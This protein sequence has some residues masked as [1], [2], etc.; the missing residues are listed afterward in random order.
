MNNLQHISKKKSI[1]VRKNEKK[2]KLILTHKVDPDITSFI[3]N[4][5]KINDEDIQ[6]IQQFQKEVHQ[7]Q[8]KL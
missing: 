6:I 5:H 4:H 2:Q 1:F 3:D 7:L 8:Y